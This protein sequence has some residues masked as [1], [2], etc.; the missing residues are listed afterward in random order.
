M[1]ASL[2][3]A[4]AV[5]AAVRPN[6]AFH[7]R[8]RTPVNTAESAVG[9][10]F[11]GYGGGN[12]QAAGR[13]LGIQLRAVDRVP[14]LFAS[15]ALA[16]WLSNPGRLTRSNRNARLKEASLLPYDVARSSRTTCDVHCGGAHRFAAQTF[17]GGVLG[18][19]LAFYTMIMSRTCLEVPVQ[20]IKWKRR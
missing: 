15:A 20:S 9:T 12:R 3:S 16:F 13:F 18:G 2:T 5:V 11:A 10:V 17:L 19:N 8:W 1:F 6:A 4:G 14:F 7:R